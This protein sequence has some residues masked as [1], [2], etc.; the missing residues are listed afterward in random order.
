V[1]RHCTKE[2]RLAIDFLYNMAVP[3]YGLPTII[4]VNTFTA[5]APHA[6]K[7]HREHQIIF[8]IHRKAASVL[9]TVLCHD[10]HTTVVLQPMSSL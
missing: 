10:S 3:P 6:K 1:Q 4:S 7:I 8:V 9:V 2:T 5:D